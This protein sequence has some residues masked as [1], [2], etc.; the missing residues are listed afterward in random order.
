MSQDFD[1]NVL[2]LVKQNGFNLYGYMCGFEKFKEELPNEKIFSNSFTCK[3]YSHEHVLKVW[4]NKRDEI[5]VQL[6]LKM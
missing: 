2:D 1:S 3:N 4:D 5:L 6:V